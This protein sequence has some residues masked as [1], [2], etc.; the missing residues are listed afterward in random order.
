MD[1]PEEAADILSLHYLVAGEYRPGVALC[2]GRGQARG[3]GLCVRRSRGLVRRARGRRPPGCEVATRT[4]PTI[5]A[6]QAECWYRAAEFEKAADRYRCCMP[7]PQGDP[8]EE[9]KLLLKRA[10]VEEKLGKYNRALRWAAR[11]RKAVKGLDDREATRQAAQA[12]PLVRRRCC[13]C[14]GRQRDALRWARRGVVAAEAADDPERARGS[15]PR[16]GVG[17]RRAR[18]GGSA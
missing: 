8:V 7:A 1:Q 4:S 2:V 6:A 16:D 9:A 17:V 13:K 14:E 10:G 11:A 15:V 18:Q 3:R 5:Y 12:S